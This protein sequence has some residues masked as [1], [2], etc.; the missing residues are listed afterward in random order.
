MSAQAPETKLEL[1]VAEQKLAPETAQSLL[2]SYRPFFDQAHEL[3]QQAAAL[4]VKDATCVT[5]IKESRRLRLELVKIR[6]G[7]DKLRKSMKEESMRKSRAVDGAFNILKFMV[8]PIEETLLAQEQFAERAEA[9]RKAK[10]KADRSAAL[11]PYGWADS[12]GFNLAEMSADDFEQLLINTISRFDA[13]N[14]RRAKE[15][16]D[17]IA[18]EKAEREEQERIRAENARLKLEADEREKA[19]KAEREKAERERQEIEEKARAEKAAADAARIA[20]E[21]K[22]AE[23]KAAAEAKAK[24]ERDAIELK[25]KQERE[26]I[27]RKASEEKA[28]LQAEAK[29]ARER[30]EKLA[31]EQRKVAEAA[32]EQERQARAKAEAELQVI[33]DNEAKKKAEEEE[34]ARKAANAP[35]REKLMAFKDVISNAAPALSSADRTAKLTAQVAILFA[36][37]D[38]RAW[39]TCN[40]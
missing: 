16:A 3:V 30:A 22:V 13:E 14:E 31:E 6:T 2:T 20:A 5:E 33:R 35:D 26:E 9:E 25:A 27:E 4:S 36:W 28:K 12:P 7:A 10:L 8:E 38:A 23:E 34:V 39:R 19:M 15:E 37:I 17:R 29:A 24:A 18:K 1:V 11:E 32:Q 21:K 40:A